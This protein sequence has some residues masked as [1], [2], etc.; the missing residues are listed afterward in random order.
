MD[1]VDLEKKDD[2]LEV[3]VPKQSYGFFY[4]DYF[5]S[6]KSTLCDEKYDSLDS[7]NFDK[8]TKG[9]L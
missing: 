1:S 7:E 3:K 5:F 4:L 9:S 6:K 2:S 8:N